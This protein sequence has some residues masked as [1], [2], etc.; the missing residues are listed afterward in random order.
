MEELFLKLGTA[1]QYPFV[2][3]AIIVGVLI[4]LCSSLLGVTLVLKRFSFIGDGLSHV[5]FGAIAVSARFIR[6]K[7]SAALRRIWKKWV[8]A[9]SAAAVTAS[10]PAVSSSAYYWRERSAPRGK[11][12][13]STSR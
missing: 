13:C 4:A 5:A 9:T 6:G 3:Y 2:R 7:K 11:C 8:S 10:C 12:S 1:L